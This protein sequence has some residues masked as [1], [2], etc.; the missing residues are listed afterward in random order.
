M[1]TPLRRRA[2]PWL[3]G[4]ALLV[5]SGAAAAQAP[6][7]AT[8][9]PPLPAASPEDIRGLV[10]TLND[11]AARARLVGELNALLDAE[12]RAA[13]A[14]PATPADWVG[15]ALAEISA[16]M[17]TLTAEAAD[18]GQMARDLPRA[19]AWLRAQLSDDAARRE[20]LDLVARLVIVLVGAGGVEWL[21]TLLIARPRLAIERWS[22]PRAAGRWL[23]LAARV[24]LALVP[25]SAFVGTA[26][27]ILPLATPDET[28]RLV[29]VAVI[30]ANV[31]VRALLGAARRVLVPDGRGPTPAERTRRLFAL[32]DAGARYAY[33][34]IGRL[35]RV[36]IYGF[37]VI[38]AAALLG[39]PRSVHD[40]LLR[41]LGLAVTIMLVVLIVQNRDGI[42]RRIAGTGTR[43]GGSP[44][45][46]P[47]D[48]WQVMRAR[49]ADVWH[50]L[51]A[52]YVVG[53]FLVWALAIPD[54]FSYLASATLWTAAALAALRAALLLLRRLGTHATR[55][56]TGDDA[57]TATRARGYLPLAHAAAR[58]VLAVLAAA[59][60][61]QAWGVEV[62]ARLESPLGHRILVSA[63]SIAVILALAAAAWEIASLMIA[64]SLALGGAVDSPHLRAARL[65]T[66]L[67]LL[68][69]ALS[70]AIVVL[71]TLVVLSELGIDIAPLLAGAGVVGLA[72]GFGAQTLVKDVITGLFFLLEDT[73]NVGDVVDVGG[74]RSGLVE[75]MSIRSI[76]LRDLDGSVHTVPFS[77]VPAIKNMT[78]DFSYA[79]LDLFVDY[80]S[81][82]ERALATVRALDEAM[83]ADA[84]F[85]ALMLE[86][87]QIL[88]VERFADNAVVVR[89]RVK[90]LPT[91]RWDVAREF[92]RRVKPAFDRAGIGMVAAVPPPEPRE[93]SPDD[94]GEAPRAVAH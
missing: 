56:L 12:R 90:T 54:G 17:T 75:S 61:L 53:A 92:N 16:G 73:V 45:G 70:V 80:R 86:P 3:L 93:P 62:W 57:A 34:W 82:L 23:L 30:N 27:L 24:L 33:R 68:R 67:P 11:P 83:R 5:L 37:F 22:A 63:F 40:L 94:R 31:L 26:Y 51:A 84:T 59:T 8:P 9:S 72:I 77:A 21:V 69:N 65:R 2:L 50:V 64:H 42:G 32:D 85:G 14:A 60:I 66:L 55:M 7:P 13:P 91:R 76:R 58:A 20:T 39:V 79:V 88:G 15:R 1:R 38:S 28:A 49:A 29:A 35:S 41:A 18:A 71:T 19:T 89:C 43:E 81:D 6:A 78:K 25:I 10:A 87:L 48:E 52:C 44:D 36:G 74:G 47:P 46:R 4:L